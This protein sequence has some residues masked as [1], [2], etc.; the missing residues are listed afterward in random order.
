MQK[1]NVLKRTVAVLLSSCFCFTVK[2]NPAS[3]TPITVK[4]Q[5]VIN[6]NDKYVY[7]MLQLALSYSKDKYTTAVDCATE[8]T[9]ARTISEVESGVTDIMWTATDKEKE[10]IL[11]PI[12]IPLYK[13]LFGYRVLLINKDNLSKFNHIETIDD[14]KKLTLGQGSSWADTKILE[15]NGF[16]VVKTMKYQSLIYMLD[17][18]R[19]DAFPR[20]VHEPWEELNTYSKLNLAV[21]PNIML[22]YR[23]PF[24]LFV[25]KNNTSLATDIDRGFNVAIAD[26]SFDKH[27]YS[28]HSVRAAISYANM[29]HR[30]VF[31]LKNP[32]LPDET[33]IN[34]P[35]LWLDPSKL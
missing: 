35:E 24:Y 26:G 11:L 4:V 32:N 14:L 16:N 8:K 21:E 2:A 1:S 29:S 20:G 17:G 13:G 30:K 15:A 33:P 27:F 3:A 34:R 22:V 12:R 7:E 9:L 31:E 28:N 6:D 19:F 10:N 5:C 18:G 23:M 25:N